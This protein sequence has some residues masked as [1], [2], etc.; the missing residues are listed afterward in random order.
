MSPSSSL[1]SS[2][3]LDVVE[4]LCSSYFE[5]DLGVRL[6]FV[7]RARGLHGLIP[8]TDLQIVEVKLQVQDSKICEATNLR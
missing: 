1:S 2:S 7:A 8:V 6:D 5:V 3:D 4:I